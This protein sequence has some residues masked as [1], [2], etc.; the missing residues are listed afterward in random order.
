MILMAISITA[1]SH[2]FIN[3]GMKDPG[4]YAIETEPLEDALDYARGYSFVYY[5]DGNNDEIK[6]MGRTLKSAYSSALS[7]LFKLT[8]PAQQYDGFVNLAALNANLGQEME[9]SEELYGILT[10]ALAKT[11]EQKGYHLF[12]GALN[13]LWED[14]LV[15]TEPEEFDPALNEDMRLRLEGL[16][17]KT[18][19]LSNFN[20]EL[21]AENGK[22]TC[23]LTVSADYLS[24]LEEQECAPVILDLGALRE[25][26]VL[27]AVAKVMEEAGYTQGYLTAASG[28]ILNLSGHT[29]EAFYQLYDLTAD[30]A[31]KVASI[32]MDKGSAFCMART[33][34]LTDPELGYYTVKNQG[35]T[36]YRHPLIPA[37]GVYRDLLNTASGIA[38]Q[39]DIVA[40]KYACITMF[41][42][43]NWEQLRE[44]V[45]QQSLK[46]ACVLRQEPGII[47][48]N[49]PVTV[50]GEQIIRSFES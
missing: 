32:P 24:Y 27:S 7:R 35:Q 11:R 15:L 34:P 42:C 44:F 23:C 28:L 8:D 26:Y 33:F 43:E 48:A 1:F 22:Y 17:Q 30:G 2:G 39:G 47:Y 46:I 31:Q 20:L 25:S 3:M 41:D 40:A 45:S 13:T 6:L 49:T 16:G 36:L 14:I 19:D 4:Y 18:K 50:E 21:K 9:I 37:D 10:D 12:A 29:G 5:L 38:P